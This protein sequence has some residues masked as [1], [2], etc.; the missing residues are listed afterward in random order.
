MKKLQFSLDK[1]LS[2]RTFYEKEAETNLVKAVSRREAIQLALNETASAIFQ[3]S[4]K[5]S[6]SSP[7]IYMPDLIAAENYI[8]GLEMRRDI[9]LK[10]AVIAEEEIKKKREEYIK[11]SK[12][13]QILSRLKEKKIE[14]WK[15][16]CSREEDNF[17]DDI[18]TFRSNGINEMQVSSGMI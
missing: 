8:K 16:E 17:I 9:L 6:P 3:T 14:E 18:V 7:N 10:E 5:L 4:K 13:R 11:A 12:K 1:I 2:L 15:K